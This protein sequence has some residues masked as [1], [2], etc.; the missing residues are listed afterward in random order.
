M[1]TPDQANFYMYIYIIFYAHYLLLSRFTG[2]HFNV[3]CMNVHLL[4]VLQLIVSLVNSSF[5]HGRGLDVKRPKVFFTTLV[6]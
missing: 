1:F 5:A 4:N 6:K 2:V 3:V